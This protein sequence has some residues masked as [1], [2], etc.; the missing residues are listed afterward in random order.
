MKLQCL[1]RRVNTVTEVVAEYVLV[2]QAVLLAPI[3]ML[4]Q[5]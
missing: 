5:S 2:K 4:L 1:S 3:F